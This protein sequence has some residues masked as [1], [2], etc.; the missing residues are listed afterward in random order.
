MHFMVMF[1]IRYIVPV[2]KAEK[3]VD[4]EVEKKV[5]IGFPQLSTGSKSDKRKE[6]ISYVKSQRQS[7]DLEKQARNQTRKFV[8]CAFVACLLQ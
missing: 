1:S 5:D 3:N 8:C 2:T 4:P 7:S 6:R